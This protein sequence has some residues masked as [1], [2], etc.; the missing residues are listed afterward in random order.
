MSWVFNIIQAILQMQKVKYT[1]VQCFAFD[2]TITQQVAKLT[3]TSGSLLKEMED[4][5]IL[6]DVTALV[7]FF[8]LV[9]F[10]CWLC[11]GIFDTSFFFFNLEN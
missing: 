9:F 11:I 4:F 8:L 3:L 5:C 10:L 7:L 6:V 1:E 2:H